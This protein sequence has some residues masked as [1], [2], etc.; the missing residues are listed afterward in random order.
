MTE[1]DYP[2]LASFLECWFT[3][4]HDFDELVDVLALMQRLDASENLRDL[5]EEMHRLHVQQVSL[6][7]FNAFSQRHGGRRYTP[8]RF[9]YLVEQVLDAGNSRSITA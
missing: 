7:E 1:Q 3:N 8:A 2:T 4:D 6:A 9:Q 5:R